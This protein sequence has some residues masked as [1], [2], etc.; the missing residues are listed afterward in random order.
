MTRKLVCLR[1]TQVMMLFSSDLFVSPPS[2]PKSYDQPNNIIPPAD[3]YPN[4][5]KRFGVVGADGKPQIPAHW[6]AALSNGGTTGQIIGLIV[7]TSYMYTPIFTSFH[8]SYD[9]Y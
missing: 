9:R 5:V 6:Q 4:F 8:H 3:A 1:P 2:S 7:S